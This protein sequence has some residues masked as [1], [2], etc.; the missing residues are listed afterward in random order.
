MVDPAF[1]RRARRHP[2]FVTGL[3]LTGLLVMVALVSVWWTPVAPD[4][5]DLEAMLAGP[6]AAHWLGTDVTWGH[7]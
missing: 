7:C 4:E 6:S 2:G 5:M 3:L 1:W